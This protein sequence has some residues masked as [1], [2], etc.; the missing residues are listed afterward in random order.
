MLL[1]GKAENVYRQAFEIILHK[2]SDIGIYFSPSVF[3]IEFEAAVIKI[4]T[5]MFFNARLQLCRFYLGQSWYRH[6]QEY[7]FSQDYKGRTPLE[8]GFI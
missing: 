5:D 2:C 8:T 7:H 4:M 1:H 3:H 6:I